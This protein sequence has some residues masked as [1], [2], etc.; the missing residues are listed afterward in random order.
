M[1]IAKLTEKHFCPK[2]FQW[3]NFLGLID[4]S[5]EHLHRRKGSNK[6]YFSI[7][8][9]RLMIRLRKWLVRWQSCRL[10]ARCDAALFDKKEDTL[11]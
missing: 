3:S 5:S 2:T 9:G 11:L 1:R 7:L 10:M 6:N 4:L 8:L